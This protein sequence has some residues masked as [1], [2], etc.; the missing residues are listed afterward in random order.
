MTPAQRKF[1]QDLIASMRRMAQRIEPR[2]RQ[3]SD[4]LKVAAERIDALSS[5]APVEPAPQL[6]Q[7]GQINNQP[8]SNKPDQAHA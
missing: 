2:S 6:A 3:L 4:A 8:A 5:A 7:D 1:D